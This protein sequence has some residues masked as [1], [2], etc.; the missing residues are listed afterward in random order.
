MMICRLK[1]CLIV[2]SNQTFSDENVHEV[3]SSVLQYV[4]LPSPKGAITAAYGVD[5]IR[6]LKVLI[7][8]G[9]DLSQICQEVDI[10]VSR[11]VEA[12][13]RITSD[14]LPKVN[15]LNLIRLQKDLVNIVN[16]FWRKL[17]RGELPENEANFPRSATKRP[18]LIAKLREC[19]IFSHIDFFIYPVDLGDNV[20]VVGSYFKPESVLEVGSDTKLNG[21]FKLSPPPQ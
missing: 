2:K 16:V 15:T 20:L 10:S 6:V 4:G 9:L 13:N 8:K 21:Q 3:P 12:T 19:E 7:T 5:G 14:M 18:D 17:F 1:T 11:D